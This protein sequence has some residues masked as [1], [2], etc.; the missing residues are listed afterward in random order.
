[1]CVCAC[2]CACACACVAQAERE[3]GISLSCDFFI[4]KDCTA[5][6]EEGFFVLK[7]DQVRRPR[8]GPHSR[9]CVRRL[10][11]HEAQARYA[12]VWFH[13]CRARMSPYRLC[14]EAC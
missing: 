3:C 11:V 7:E 6:V 5:A 14:T 1:V 10:D 13:S 12:L 2:A 9:V 8:K 4:A